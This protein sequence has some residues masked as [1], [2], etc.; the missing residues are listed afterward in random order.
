VGQELERQGDCQTRGR[1]VT[2]I[3]PTP[4]RVVW[5]HPGRYD[6]IKARAGQP[7]AAH[8]AYVHNDTEVNLMVIDADG[9]PRARTSIFLSPDGLPATGS[10]KPSWCEW[11]PYQKGQAAKTEELETK[12]GGKA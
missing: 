10:D 12:L 9:Y 1:G 8:I 2:M 6:T 11:M 3:K 5:F 7:L 4:G